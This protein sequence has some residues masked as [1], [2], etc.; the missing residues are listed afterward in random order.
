MCHCLLPHFLSSEQKQQQVEICQQNL[1]LFQVGGDQI[2]SKMGDET[3]AHYYDAPS[4]REA[5]LWIPQEE[6]PLSIVKTERPSKKICYAA[7]SR[8]TGLVV[9]V[10]V[11]D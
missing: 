1:K 8:I 6:V 7:Y 2:I 4:Q 9:T 5:K 3:C 11:D 10:K